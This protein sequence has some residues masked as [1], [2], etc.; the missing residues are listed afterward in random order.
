M[1][2]NHETT[3][4][5]ET[6]WENSQDYWNEL[7][8]LTEEDDVSGVEYLLLHRG[9][10]SN[11]KLPGEDEIWQWLQGRAENKLGRKLRV[12]FDKETGI[13]VPIESEKN[14]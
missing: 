9:E 8:R 2:N 12:D 6:H 10:F 5:S 7:M 11:E 13:I 14:K 4:Q 1:E 3:T